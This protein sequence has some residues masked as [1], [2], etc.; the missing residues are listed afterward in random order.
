MAT[1]TAC[2][3]QLPDGARFCP[4]CGAAAATAQAAAEERKLAT[5]LF[6]DLVGSTALADAEDPERVRARLDRFYDAMTEEIVRTGGTVES[7]AG[8]SVMAAFGAPNALEDHAERALHA[9]LAMQRRLTELFGEALALRIGVNTGDVVIGR[10][11]EGTSFVT[12][13]AVN[14]GARLE[15]AA[16]PGEVLA[17]ERT[18][19]AARGAFEF[20]DRRVVEA[21]G[22]SEGV[23][24]R[25]VLRALSLM[26]PRGVGGMRRVFVG[27]ESELDLLRAI[28]RRAVSQEEPHLVSIIGEPGLGKTRLVRELWDLLADEE[29][30]SP[31]RRTGRC[32]AYGDGITYWPLGE[33]LKEQ[34]PT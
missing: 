33:I 4:A 5:V 6:A 32:L 16:A 15:Q 12:G 18:V 30:A 3:A 29:P 34:R 20:G 9:A 2:G 14:V 23:P 13:D 28:F 31:L 11:R 24:S 19:A 7:F 21:K 17:G 10:A 1:C 26:R 27:R 8:D 22:K 25:R